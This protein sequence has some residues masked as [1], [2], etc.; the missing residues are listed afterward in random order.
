MARFLC[1]S[2]SLALSPLCLCFSYQIRRYCRDYVDFLS[3]ATK[4]M[5]RTSIVTVTSLCVGTLVCGYNTSE[6]T[7]TRRQLHQ[8]AVWRTGARG[9]SHLPELSLFQIKFVAHCKTELLASHLWNLC[10]FCA[11]IFQFFLYEITQKICVFENRVLL[12][13][14]LSFQ[15]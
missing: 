4:S 13:C 6:G 12:F 2:A 14:G 9:L 3:Q 7:C 1:V 8:L 15:P 10:V 11:E 5:S